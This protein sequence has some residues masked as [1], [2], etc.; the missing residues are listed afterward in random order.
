MIRQREHRRDVVRVEP[1]T[2]PLVP[3]QREEVGEDALVRDDARHDRAEHEHRAQP[4][5]PASPGMR[6]LQL[7]MEAIEMLAAAR[8][9]GVDDVAGRGIEHDLRRATLGGLGVRLALFEDPRDRGPRI[10]KVDIPLDVVRAD[11][12]QVRHRSLRGVCGRDRRRAEF[13][14]HPLRDLGPE[15]ARRSGQEHREQ[16]PSREQPQ[17]AVDPRHALAQRSSDRRGHG[18]TPSSQS[19]PPPNDRDTPHCGRYSQKPVFVE[20]PQ[21]DAGIDRERQDHAPARRF[22]ARDGQQA[23]NQRRQ[24]GRRGIAADQCRKAS[25]RHAPDERAHSSAR[26][27]RAGFQDP[28][29][30]E[31]FVIFPCR[32]SKPPLAGFASH[33]QYQSG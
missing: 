13:R 5:Q 14:L 11:A 17:P 27:K 12:L 21:G 16:D 33:Y 25:E 6:Q 8:L 28:A 31:H 7:E 22:D 24:H 19:N 15:I 4:G 9:A 2:L 32:A 30:H 10:G 23:R 26:G 18:R 20:A 1:A 3:A 29:V